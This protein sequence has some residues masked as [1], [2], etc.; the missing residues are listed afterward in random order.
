MSGTKSS[1]FREMT[2]PVSSR[3]TEKGRKGKGIPVFVSQ[4]RRQKRTTASGASGG[5]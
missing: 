5:P 2:V 4:E 3:P 1:A